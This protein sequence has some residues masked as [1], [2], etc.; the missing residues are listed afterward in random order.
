VVTYGAGR[1][2]VHLDGRTWSFSFA[3]P[4]STD[5]AGGAHGAIAGAHVIA[6][7]PG[8]IVKVAVR[9]GEAV[10]EHALLVM[11]EAMKME[12]RIEAPAAAVVSSVL[13]KEGQVVAAGAALVTLK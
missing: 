10:E 12:H 13:V 6:P 8:K 1:F 5:S 4:P 9:E 7:M 2:N 11:L 3:A